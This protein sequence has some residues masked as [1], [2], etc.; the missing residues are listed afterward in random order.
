MASPRDEREE[1]VYPGPYLNSNRDK[2]STDEE[3]TVVGEETHP[4]T[5]DQSRNH[6]H[7]NI[8]TGGPADQDHISRFSKS[9]S[10]NREQQ[11]RLDDELKLLRIERE[12]SA[13]I[14]E[15]A[16]GEAAAEIGATLEKTQSASVRRERSR[17]EELVDDFDVATNPLHERAQIYKPPES[18]ASAFGRFMKSVHNSSFIVRYVTYIAPVVLI[19]LV[20]LLVGA[21]VPS[22]KGEDGALV[23]GVKLLWFMVWLEIVWLTLWLGR[24]STLGFSLTS[25]RYANSTFRSP[26]SYFHILPDSLRLCSPTARKNGGT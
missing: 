25:T 22:A 5:R 9:P 8:D 7:L 12:I 3:G 24:V 2:S 13:K 16:A 4:A 23:G 18:P 17:R 21:F 1:P 6:L 20:P 10:G 14:E 26:R 11:H 19:L 15:D